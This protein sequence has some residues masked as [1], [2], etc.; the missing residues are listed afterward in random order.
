VQVVPPFNGPAEAALVAAHAAYTTKRSFVQATRSVAV[1]DPR[2]V[3]VL[4]D[5]VPFA[6]LVVPFV[7]LDDVLAVVDEARD[8]RADSLED[9]PAE[10]V[11]GVLGDRVRAF[12]GLDEA[13]LAVVAVGEGA[14]A[15]EAALVVVGIRDAYV[16]VELDRV[17]RVAVR[18]AR[19][20]VDGHLD[21]VVGGAING[22]IRAIDGELAKPETKLAPRD[23]QFG[24]PTTY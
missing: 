9:A 12:L 5:E 6:L 4:G 20:V 10:H 19:L 2:P 18:A 1:V 16:G 15:R 23:A 22:C 7:F 24:A 17:G 21:L 3:D 8:R 13:V 14:V 11:V